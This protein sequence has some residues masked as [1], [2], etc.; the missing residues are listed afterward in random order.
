MLATGLVE[1]SG[2]I[3]QTAAP[4]AAVKVLTAQREGM[5]VAKGQ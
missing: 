1:Y 2:Q 4:T 3:S 5:E